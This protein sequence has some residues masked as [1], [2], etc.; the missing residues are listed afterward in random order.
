MKK[1]AKK[2]SVKKYNNGGTTPSAKPAKKPT[3]AY[4]VMDAPGATP[5]RVSEEE[6]KKFKGTKKALPLNASGTPT[7]SGSGGE[8]YTNYSNTSSYKKGGTVKKAKKK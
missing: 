7:V 8:K 4:M 2:T 5:R 1:S 6:Y 3:H